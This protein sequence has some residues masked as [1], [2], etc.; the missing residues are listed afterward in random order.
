M[1]GAKSKELKITTDSTNN[2]ITVLAERTV[3]FNFAKILG[4]TGTKVNAKAVAG[5]GTVGK[6]KGIVPFGIQEQELEFGKLYDLKVGAPPAF[7]AGNFGALALGGKGANRYRDNIKYGYQEWVAIGDILE[8]ES[9]NMSGPT[10]QGVNYRISQENH[11]PCTPDNFRRDCPR[12]VTVPV[13]EPLGNKN[14]IKEVRVKGFAAFLIKEVAGQG[15]ESNVK[16]YFIETIVPGETSETA[17]N[18]GL[19]AVKLSQ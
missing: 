16:G 5:V 3:P 1:N 19:R 4:F 2:T 10:M 18:Y 8:T 11:S 15:N 13:Y 7:G 14:H 6:V 17:G 9:G 12:L